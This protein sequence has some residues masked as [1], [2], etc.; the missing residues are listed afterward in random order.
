MSCMY[1][2]FSKHVFYG[3]FET[4][5]NSI[6]HLQMQKGQ[7]DRTKVLQFTTIKQRMLRYL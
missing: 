4:V 7:E 3:I 5:L 2:Y 6:L 1:E